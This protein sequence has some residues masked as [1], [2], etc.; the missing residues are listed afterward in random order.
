MLNPLPEKDLAT[1]G[2]VT[3]DIETDLEGNV[4]DIDTAWRSIETNL[5]EHKTFQAWAEW[6]QWLCATAK[7]D[8]RFRVIYAHNGGGFDW[9]SLAEF[10]LTK[11]GKANR[12][13]LS[14]VCAGSKMVVLIVKVSDRFT[15]RFCD[16]LQLLRSSLDKLALQ[17]LGEGKR[18]IG[19]KLP[20]EIKAENPVLYYEYLYRDTES[21]LLILEKSLDL[22]R[23]HIA[24][25]DTWGMT[26]GSSAMKVFRTIG[27]RESLSIPWDSET[28]EFLRLGYRGG[29][30]E[31]F[32]RGYFPEI[33]AYDINSL[34]PS[35]MANANVPAS[36]RTVET[37]QF[38]R[39]V[40]GVYE[41]D[42]IQER[43][44][45][46]AVL[47]SSGASSYRGTGVYYQP[48]LE[49]LQ[50]I[51]PDAVI[52]VKRGYIFLDAEKLFS[53]YVAKLYALRLENK[54]N[55][56]DLLCKYLLNSL[57]GKFGQKP[58]REKIVAVTSLDQLFEMIDSDTASFRP[59]DITG[60]LCILEQETVCNHEHVG[61]AG[62]ITSLAR[63]ALHVGLCAAGDGLVY[64]DTDSVHSTGTI[65]DDFIS[66]RLG[67]YKLEFS[68]EGVYAGKKLYAL[69]S[70]DGTEK[71]RS[72]GISVGGRNGTRLSFDD[73]CRVTEGQEIACH[74]K[75]PATPREV[76][77]GKKACK[78]IDR[79]RTIRMT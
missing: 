34:Y 5:I 41:V 54:G 62:F 8:E 52:N 12:L 28:K 22:L 38:Q 73:L 10:L 66:D 58:I 32:Q 65:P 6:W 23:S 77:A 70:P 19:D 51:D 29:R 3:A 67:D 69:R 9:L 21:L 59:L 56:I 15:I 31:C 42:Y 44:D 48:E 53:N 79:K 71:V 76:F 14:A 16:S 75:K 68:G 35:V 60:E 13:E 45:I 37:R 50:D 40:L 24:P 33:N 57:Y 11:Q 63:V 39:G 49:R 4:L 64:C 55:A 20:H 25:I 78:F 36:D 61:I 46:P 43:N 74:Y 27:L 72:K 2:F 47:L 18:D 17:F 7:T 26:I 1:D 30:V